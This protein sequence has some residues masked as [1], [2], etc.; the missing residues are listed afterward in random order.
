MFRDRALVAA[1]SCLF[2]RVAL[3]GQSSKRMHI[4]LA[5]VLGAEQN[6]YERQAVWGT[7]GTPRF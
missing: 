6:K 2:R 3:L 1:A 4:L 7:V 5:Q